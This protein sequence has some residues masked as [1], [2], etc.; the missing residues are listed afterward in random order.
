MVR[1]PGLRGASYVT[2][3]GFETLRKE[4]DWLWREERRRVTAEVAAAAAQGDRSE[5]AEYIYGKKRL[6]EI[7]RR[8]RFLRKRLEEVEVVRPGEVGDRERVFFGAWVT[9][10]DEDGVEHRYRL[11][12]PDEF[13]VERGLVSVES[14]IGRVL[15]GKREGD[16][17]TVQRPSGPAA[18]EILRIAYEP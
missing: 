16:E 14:P 12:G 9:L 1:T 4:L 5:N 7:D 10:E 6:R 13:D 3:E 2:P 11:V 8:V 18:Y 17:V 15:L